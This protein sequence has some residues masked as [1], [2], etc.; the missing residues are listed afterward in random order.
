LIIESSPSALILADPGGVI[1]LVNKQFEKIFGYKKD[2]VLGKNVELLIPR[3]IRSRHVQYRQQYMSS[4]DERIMGKG[5]DLTAVKK[6]GQI[7]P[8]EVWL[9]PIKLNSKTLVLASIVDITERK[10]KELEIKQAKERLTAIMDNT[11]DAIYEFDESGN[12]MTINHEA[13]INYFPENKSNKIWNIIPSETL[14]GYRALLDEVKNG[15]KVND[16]E[17]K[18]IMSDGTKK[19]V[20]IGITFIKD[21]KNRYIETARDISDRIILRNKIVEVEKS[22]ILGK[23]AE[24][25]AHHMGTPLASILLR[26]QMIKE[27]VENRDDMQQFIDKLIQI[28]KQIGYG[29]K[30]LTRILKFVGRPTFDKEKSNLNSLV[31]ESV[32]IVRP[33]LNKNK[34][35]MDIKI[36]ENYELV[37]EQNLLQMVISDLIMNAIDAISGNGKISISAHKDENEKTI[38][39]TVI[40]NGSGIPKKV[41]PF[42]FEPFY[43]TKSKIKGTGL[44]LAV[45]K[46]VVQEHNG[47]ISIE[48]NPGKG[49]KVTITLPQ[50]QEKI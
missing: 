34:V 17:T 44:G 5:R 43:T 46:N 8:V 29:Q 1:I 10:D 15:R 13:R 37:C 21:E 35:N 6:N 27:D 31:M 25:I 22:Q 11:T 2:E 40:D 42:V 26:V 50:I 49:T 39:V 47:E 3:Q 9:S 7:I 28:E 41:I 45:A 36:P 12:V 14:D 38:I 19:T 16:L 20:S 32:E 18:R 48:S 24:G 4:P 33:L 30:I 23:M